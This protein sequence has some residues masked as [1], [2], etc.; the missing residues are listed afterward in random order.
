MS[1]WD[2]AREWHQV[3][4]VH[5]PLNASKD[6][7][8]HSLTLRNRTERNAKLKHM[9]KIYLFSIVCRAN[10][11]I[12]YEQWGCVGILMLLALYGR[13]SA[14]PPSNW[15]LR[16]L[17]YKPQLWSRVTAMLGVVG[18]LLYR[19][20]KLDLAHT[21]VLQGLV[22]L[23]RWNCKGL[24]KGYEGYDTEQWLPNDGVVNTYSMLYPRHSKQ[25][26][27]RTPSQTQLTSPRRPLPRI[28][29]H[30]SVDLKG[31][32]EE[33]DVN[34]YERGRWYIHRVDKNHFCGTSG[35]RTATELYQALFE[36]LVRL[37]RDKENVPAPTGA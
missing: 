32:E 33:E 8:Y 29:S 23:M 31:M 24:P 7:V 27:Q 5:H 12:P 6:N 4:S 34:G 35:D 25:A 17:F 36:T 26:M 13:R 19:T 1:Q 28:L 9:D 14:A 37:T 20:R 10:D 22:A 21:P 18:W 2:L 11:R 3:T 16:T 15:W 30:H